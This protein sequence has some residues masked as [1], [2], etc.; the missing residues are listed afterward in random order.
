[1][2]VASVGFCTLAVSAQTRT[3]HPKVIV[4]SLDAFPAETLQDPHI[5]APTLHALMKAGAYARSM[6][7]INPTVTWPNHTAMVT[8]QNASHHHVLVNGLILD[9]RTNNTPRVDAQ[10]S[11]DQ[12]VAVPTVYDI[13]HKAGLTTA[14]VDWVA[15]MHAPTIDW[16]FAEKPD[17][18]G[19]IEKDLIAQGLTTRSDLENFG[20]PGQAWRDRLYTAAAVDILRKHHPDL[21][22]LHLLALDGI[23][24]RTG[25][26]TDADYNTIAFLDD[27]VREVL[28]AVEANGD[29]AKTTFIIVSDHGQSS[30]HKHLNPEVILRKENLG[31][32]SP[33]PTFAIPDGGFA[34]VYQKQATVQSIA[35]LKKLFSVQE[36]IRSA[37]TPDEAS[38]MGWPTPLQTSQAPDLLLYA[39]TDYAFARSKGDAFVTESEQVGQHGYPND[40]PLM[41]AIFI[42]SGSG[43][44]KSGEIPSFSNLDVGPTIAKLLGLSIPE[45]EGKP[46]SNILR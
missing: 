9:E 29:T 31:A 35:E 32:G 45:T 24:H 27:R 15:I 20:R 40:E 41:Q 13:A 36:G 44:L 7:P 21:L 1:M 19:S 18:D 28:E 11:K 12:L 34:L 23:E 33:N 37:L 2:G 16:R 17:V 8:G 5:A 30:V 42:A 39:K 43:I 4:I 10:A 6:Q 25:Y 26:G 3:E 22:M 14:E 38:K 46:L